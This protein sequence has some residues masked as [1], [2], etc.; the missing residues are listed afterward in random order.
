V[1]RYIV[2][3][4]FV[5]TMVGVTLAL[6]GRLHAFNV[7][8]EAGK[9]AQDLSS[10][11]QRAGNSQSQLSITY[12]LRE[13]LGGHE[14]EITIDD[15]VTV[16]VQDLGIFQRVSYGNL[17]VNSGGPFKG[18]DTLLIVGAWGEVTVSKG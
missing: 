7:E 15:F 2:L 17:R 4:A 12:S 8:D 6:H 11:I 10:T 14:Y 5:A 18:G 13:G 3:A 9:L 1:W 16:A